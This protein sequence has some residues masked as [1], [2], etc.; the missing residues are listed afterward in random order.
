M[1]IWKELFGNYLGASLEKR[2]SK[3][4]STETQQNIEEN[5]PF[6]IR[7]CASEENDNC[8]FCRRLFESNKVYSRSDIETMSMRLG[9]SVWDRRGGVYDKDGNDI[10]S[11]Y[12]RQDVVTQKIDEK[13]FSSFIRYSYC[14]K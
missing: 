11:C 1:S 9:Y 6:Q 14:Q 13:K 10:C 3:K 4:A 12:W 8:A 5:K 7:P 2:F